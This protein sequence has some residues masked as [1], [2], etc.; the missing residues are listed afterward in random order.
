MVK[1]SS[2]STYCS[3]VLLM[4][5]FKNTLKFTSLPALHLKI[6]II[7]FDLCVD[8]VGVRDRAGEGASVSNL[9]FKNFCRALFFGMMKHE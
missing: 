5:V 9:N 6:G 1:R 8:V 7:S 3:L 2:D 4:P